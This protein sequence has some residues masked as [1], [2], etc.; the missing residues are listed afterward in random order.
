MPAIDYWWN[1]VIYEDSVC[2]MKEIYVMMMC[3]KYEDMRTIILN[4]IWLWRPMKEY[5]IGKYMVCIWRRRRP[6]KNIV[7]MENEEKQ[8]LGRYNDNDVVTEGR[9]WKP[10][11]VKIWL[12][13]KQIWQWRNNMKILRSDSVNDKTWRKKH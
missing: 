2:E 10:M 12:L 5:M 11:Y 9:R 8:W 6:I 4:E 13:M 7:W 1:E 3:G